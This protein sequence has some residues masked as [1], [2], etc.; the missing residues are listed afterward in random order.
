MTF[1]YI[2]MLHFDPVF[3]IITSLILS[4]LFDTLSLP[5]QPLLYLHVSLCFPFIGFLPYR[6]VGKGLFSRA[7]QQYLLY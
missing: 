7:S 1:S 3:P 4:L 5:K 6:A 2:Y